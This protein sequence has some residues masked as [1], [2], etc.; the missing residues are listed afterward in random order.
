MN[1]TILLGACGNLQGRGRRFY[2]Q[3]IVEDVGGSG[4]SKDEQEEDEEAHFP[5]VGCDSLR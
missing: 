3:S 2:L 1:Q 4:N 5:V